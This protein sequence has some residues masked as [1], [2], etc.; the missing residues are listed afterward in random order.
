[1]EAYKHSRHELDILRLLARDEKEIEAGKGYE[2]DEV[3]ADTDSLLKENKTLK[4]LFNP[5]RHGVRV[6]PIKHLSPVS[7][8]NL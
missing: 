2:L 6:C 3:L 8:I 5:S 1:M 7:F 4:L